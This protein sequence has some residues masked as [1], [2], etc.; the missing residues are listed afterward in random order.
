MTTI[1]TNNPITLTV[2][3]NIRIRPIFKQVDIIETATNQVTVQAATTVNLTWRDCFDGTLRD[4]TPPSDYVQVTYQGAGGGTCWEPRA[5]IGFEPD[6][7]KV[8]TFDWRRGTNTLP[9]AKRFY[10]NNPSSTVFEVKITTNEQLTV[11][12][13]TFTSN[14]RSRQ[15]VIITPTSELLDALADGVST[16]DFKIELKEVI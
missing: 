9:E 1:S 15:L 11:T 10:V 5:Q 13:S 3:D 14:P 2:S 8:L 7:N 4:G 16:L 12:P 6:L